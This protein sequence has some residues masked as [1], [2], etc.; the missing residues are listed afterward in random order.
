MPMNAQLPR[1]AACCALVILAVAPIAGCV[2]S[3][4]IR[5]E[6]GDVGR[7]YVPGQITSA[8]QTVGYNQMPFK[9]FKTDNKVKRTLRVDDI[10]EMRFLRRGT[11]TYVAVA[12]FNTQTGR[13]SVRLAEDGRESLTEKGEAELALIRKALR[14]QFGPRIVP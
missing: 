5:F 10:T 9:S 12:Q 13:V 6:T 1:L 11:P 14:D 7:A 2:L 4:E 3:N 8:L